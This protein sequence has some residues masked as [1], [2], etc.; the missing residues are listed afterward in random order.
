MT[1]EEHARTADTPSAADR[2]AGAG[3]KTLGEAMVRLNRLDEA[4][5]YLRVARRLET[6]PVAGKEISRRSRR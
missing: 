1:D 2:T 5:R 3:C 4:L 6:A